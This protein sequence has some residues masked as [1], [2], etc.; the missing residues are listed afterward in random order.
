MSKWVFSEEAF[1]LISSL[2]SARTVK[3]ISFD[4]QRTYARMRREGETEVI[5][6]HPKL[7]VGCGYRRVPGWLNVDKELLF[8][9]ASIICLKKER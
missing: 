5:P 8:A 7:H 4:I 6:P 9:Q 2:F 3:S 1:K